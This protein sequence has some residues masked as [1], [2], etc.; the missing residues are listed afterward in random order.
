LAL[1]PRWGPFLTA[2]GSIVCGLMTERH[3]GVTGES[4][5][6]LTFRQP[7]IKGK[8]N[9]SNKRLNISEGSGLESSRVTE[10][11]LQRR[12][13]VVPIFDD[14]TQLLPTRSKSRPSDRPR[15]SQ[16]RTRLSDEGDEGH[17]NVPV[18]AIEAGVMN[19]VASRCGLAA[20]VASKFASS[21]DCA[22]HK[23][24]RGS[25]FARGA[26]DRS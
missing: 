9:R 11:N 18:P 12:A 26:G 19:E 7:R 10:I 5:T 8:P 23:G 17:L 3:A 13:A 16:Y 15:A 21:L 4:L 2:R 25:I 14:G 20:S 24:T 1:A 6:T 22:L